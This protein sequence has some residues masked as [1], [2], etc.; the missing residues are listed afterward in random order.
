MSAEPANVLP[1]IA[2]I[3]REIAD[4]TT[5]NLLKAHDNV[6][7]SITVADMPLFVTFVGALVSSTL[8]GSDSKIRDFLEVRNYRMI[9]Y[10]SA[11]GTGAPGEKLGLLL[12]YF[13]LVLN[14]FGSYPHLK[15]LA[16]I[17]NAQITGDSG[18]ENSMKFANV[19]YYGIDFTLQ[20][21]GHVYRK[22]AAGD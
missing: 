6:P 19:P 15:R 5:G 10:H 9:L 13:D 16:G 21:T 11:L 22:L 4:P 7:N 3:Q 14:K 18:M 2:I 20:V 12:P 17:V 1:Q 8:D